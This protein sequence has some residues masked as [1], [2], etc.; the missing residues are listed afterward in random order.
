[1]KCSKCGAE[2]PEG[3]VFCGSCGAT[4][5]A[6]GAKGQSQLSQWWASTS[7]LVSRDPVLVVVGIGAILLCLGTFLSWVNA[8]RFE[9]TLGLQ[10]EAGP[11]VLALG[12]LLALS[13]LLA[14]GGTPGAWS[15][16][17]LVLSGVCLV[18]VFQTMIYLDDHDADI[19][20]GLYV[21]MIG[22]FATASGGLLEVMRV[23]KK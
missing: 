2:I 13:L 11:V 15:I 18:L 12:A 22:G 5:G 17:I 19:G 9:D 7:A 16:V 1:M 4:V 23:L 3:S 21:S 8:G 14:R 6:G 10:M 20:A